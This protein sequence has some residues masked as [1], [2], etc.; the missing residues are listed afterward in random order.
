MPKKG[1]E[2]SALE[3]KRLNKPGMNF[4]GG[5]PGLA[6]QVLPTGGR[7][8]ILRA[9]IAGRR[10][11]MGLGGYPEVTLARA[12]E[13]AAQYRD[14]IRVGRSPLAENHAARSALRAHVSMSFKQA[15]EN[16]IDSQRSSWS[17]PK[18]A[19]Q[20]ESTILKYALPI[21]GGLDVSHINASH[22]LRILEQP[23]EGEGKFWEVR[24]E[25]ASRLRGRL[26][27]VLDWAKGRGL[28]S[29]DNPAGW[30]GNLE[31]QLPKA[32][33]VKKV[34]HHPALT[35]DE[36]SAFV[37]KLRQQKGTAAKALEFAILTAARSGEVRGAA[38]GEI[39]LRNGLWVIPATRMKAGKDHRVP[40]SSDAVVL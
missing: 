7:T 24:T 39:D 4:V 3:T 22:I 21:I 16:F 11:D 6:L 27:K 15:A 20:W 13:K 10:R 26:E 8:W 14:Q 33:K 25:T 2:L 1:R 19:A 31:A 37:G 36:V 29:G 28:R 17:N 32:S 34:T 40:L 18:H 12:R 35:L 23:I 30:R 38:W 5:V 9:T